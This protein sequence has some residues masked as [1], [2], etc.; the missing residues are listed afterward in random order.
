MDA[1]HSTGSPSRIAAAASVV[2]LCALPVLTYAQS[3]QPVPAPIR[4]AGPIS[5]PAQKVPGPDDDFAGLHYTDQQKADIQRIQK[6]SKLKRDTVLHD[7]K[8]SPEQR[9]AMLQGLARIERLDIYKALTP[10]QQEEVRKRNLA[11][12]EAIAKQRQQ[13]AAQQR[14][15]SVPTTQR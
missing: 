10:E 9:D 1:A 15:P 11:R 13:Q 6:D 3:P 5:G 8:L 4:H 7:A 12:R 2:L 14:S